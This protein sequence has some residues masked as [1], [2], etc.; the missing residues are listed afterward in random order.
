MYLLSREV[1]LEWELLKTSTTP[2]LGDLDL[3]YINPQGEGN[4]VVAPL[5]PNN[6][7]PPTSTTAGSVTTTF[8]PQLEGFWRIRLVTGTPAQYSVLAKMEMF[9]FDNTTITT[10]YSEDIGKPAPYDINYYIQGFMVS[11]EIFG[12]FVTSRSI[13]LDEDVPGSVAI[14]ETPSQVFT[15]EFDILHNGTRIGGISFPPQALVGTITC[16]PKLLS[17]GDKLQ[18]KVTAN[19][20]DSISDVAINLVG[21]CIVVPC[22]VF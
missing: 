20:D 3:I 1:T 5:L 13:A 16:E 8:T 6:Y 14:C 12:S 21:C 10:P 18:I 7:V 11:D 19:L 15:T 9:V 17:I 4:Y 2:A 22:T